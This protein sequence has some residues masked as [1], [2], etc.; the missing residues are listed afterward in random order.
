MEYTQYQPQDFKLP[1]LPKEAKE[2]LE[3]MKSKLDKFSKAVTKENKD[4]MGIALLPPSR[5]SPEE[6][7]SNEEVEKLK[8]RI[9]VLIVIDVETKKDWSAIREGIISRVIK[10]ANEVDENIF[11]T[12]MDIAEIRENCFDAK[13][14][15]LEMIAAGAALYDPKDF[16]GA[17]KI[18]EVH[19][20]MTLKKFDKY[21][22]SYV[23][24]GSL[25]RGD[26]TSNDIDVAVV[27]D[28]T[29]V[30]KM[31]RIELKD[32]LM[33]I[34]RG[35][36]Y[37]ASQITGVKKAFHIQ[38]YIL[39]DFWDAI[40]DANPVIYTFLRDGVPIYDRGVFMPWKLLLKMGR[41]RPSPEAIDFQMDMGEKLIQR[42]KGKMIGI[43]GDDLYYAILNPAQAALMLYGIAPPTPK[44]TIEL[45]EEIFVKK[46]KL[47]EKKYVDILSKIRKYYKDIEHG[48][49]KEVKG[50][51]I[52]ELLTDAEDYIKRINKLFEQ[53][54]SRRDKESIDE[55]YN[56]CMNVVEDALK[57]NNVK[58]EK[59]SNLVS[60]FKRHL[61]DEK[62]I[63]SE[64]FLETLKTVID[65]KNSA[66]SKK[67]SWPELEKIRRESRG[68]IRGVVEYVQ[69]K[70][71]YELERAKIRFKYGDKFGE[72]LLL[73]KVAYIVNDID[74]QDKEVSR[75]VIKDDGG[76]GSLEKS[77]LEELEKEI[78]KVKIPTKV[79][80][81][82]KIFESLRNLF[83]KDI[84]I[85]VNY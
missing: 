81:K 20:N 4:I 51:D 29:D 36:G 39:T 24:V 26:A 18:S 83:G 5:I 77:N 35:M 70:R 63:F 62:K 2:K 14:E 33:A 12:V 55:M 73:D 72:A 60:L 23:A 10:K 41:I 16:L 7:L 80:I 46:E 15:I 3:A 52:D 57:A 79:F 82:E 59:Q 56:S 85:L 17:L 49:I 84:E 45:M 43:M 19:K 71:G 37:D 8:K 27:I 6:K 53:I 67:L 40:K 1:E 44:E 32:R 28:D 48:N 13:Y 65:T 54:Q 25:F 38:T 74:A 50:K 21:I 78:M 47:L 68:F 66:K 42:T 58:V 76:L 64:Q 75:A 69:R 61:I 22:V 31:T 34:I 9:N 30:K 11:V